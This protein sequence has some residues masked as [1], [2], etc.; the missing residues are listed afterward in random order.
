MPHPSHPMRLDAESGPIV[1]G[2]LSARLPI[3]ATDRIA[4]TPTIS[5]IFPLTGNAKDEMKGLGLKGTVLPA[6][7]D[8]SFLLVGFSF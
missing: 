6:E 8:D 2:S 4:I 1:D 7:R 3:K 5:Y